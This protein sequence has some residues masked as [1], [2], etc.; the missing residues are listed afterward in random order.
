MSSQQPSNLSVGAATLGRGICHLLRLTSQPKTPRGRHVG[1]D[2]LICLS[3]INLVQT[4]A[5]SITDKRS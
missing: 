3:E 4:P 2:A 5:S 1:F